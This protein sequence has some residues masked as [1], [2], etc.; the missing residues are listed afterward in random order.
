LQQDDCSEMWCWVLKCGIYIYIYTVTRNIFDVCVSKIVS[1]FTGVF[2]FVKLA[3]TYGRNHFYILARNQ[4]DALFS[5]YLKINFFCL[6]LDNMMHVTELYRCGQQA[7][8]RTFV[9]FS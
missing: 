3:V 6:S 7:T 8:T 5:Q 4:N 1:I 2:L 9:H